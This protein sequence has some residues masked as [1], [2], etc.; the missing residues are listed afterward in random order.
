MKCFVFDSFPC[1]LGD[2]HLLG[3][4]ESASLENVCL[5]RERCLLGDLCLQTW[6]KA[7]HQNP[8]LDSQ[9]GDFKTSHTHTDQRA[10][11]FPHH[12]SMCT[13]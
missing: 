12:R 7:A 2:G 3:G 6:Q 5:Q 8:G 13:M 1:A 11:F 9:P 10:S 4:T